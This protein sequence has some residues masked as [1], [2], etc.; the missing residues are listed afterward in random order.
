MMVKFSKIIHDRLTISW[1]ILDFCLLGHVIDEALNNFL[2]L[3]NPIVLKIKESTPLIPLP[4]FTFKIWI[5]GLS[6]GVLILFL[7]T[8]LVSN[9][10]KF[11]IPLIQAFSFLMILNGI[12]HI[13]GSIYFSKIIAGMISS[14]FLIIAS[15]C[16][17][18]FSVKKKKPQKILIKSDCH[19][20]Q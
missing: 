19:F 3:Y 5:I 8:P 10:N 11:V 9:R 18:Y 4:A 7:L 1:L 16:V 14:P 2:E 12:G 13:I 6:I 20:D 17:I 15:I